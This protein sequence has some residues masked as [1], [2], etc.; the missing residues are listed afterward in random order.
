MSGRAGTNKVALVTGGAVRVG[1]SISLGLAEAGY[2]VIVNYHSSVSEA[3]A[4]RERVESL[5]R[6]CV[7]APGD[8]ADEH[9]AREIVDLAR[10]HFGRL[11]LLVNN[12]SL[13]RT[14][15]LL[16]IDSDDWDRVMAVNVKG[17]FLLVKHAA[18]LLTHSRGSVVNI[19]DLS[20]LNPWTNHPHHSVSKA[21][22]LHLTR[23]MAKSLAPHVR[24]NAIGPGTVLPPEEADEEERELERRRTLV[25]SLGVPEDVVRT[26]LFLADSPF[27]TGDLIL[28]D[29]GAALT[30]R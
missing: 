5:E 19:V 17:P 18:D 15:A 13:F 26:V 6:L 28:V 30:R 14:G 25:G 11:D 2:D 8:V 12:A 29:G 1:R 23:L 9:Q 24:V 4:V 27:I 3:H 16:E 7:L 10:E 20:A 21:A 22:L